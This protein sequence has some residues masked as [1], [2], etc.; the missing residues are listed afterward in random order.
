MRKTVVRQLTRYLMV[1]WI[2]G[3]IV[4]TTMIYVTQGEPDKDDIVVIV[5]TGCIMGG[6]FWNLVEVCMYEETKGKKKRPS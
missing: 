4:L 1:A 2:I 5:S 3:M 6:I